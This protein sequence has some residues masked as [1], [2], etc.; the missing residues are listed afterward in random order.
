LGIAKIIH[1]TSGTNVLDVGTGGGFPGI[2]L[3]I[4]FP[5]TR[6]VLLDSIGKKIKVAT[7]VAQS[8]GLKNVDFRH[9]RI[10][11]EKGKYDF[12]VNRAVMPLSDL[13][14]LVQKNIAIEQRNSLPNGII[15]LKG[16]DLESEIKP[17]HKKVEIDELSSFFEEEFFGTKKLVYLPVVGAK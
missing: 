4:F 1:F 8:I 9:C 3:A 6:F 13:L 16:G 12:V 5:G 10:E 11:E 15:C 17:F 2:P 14:K 7:E